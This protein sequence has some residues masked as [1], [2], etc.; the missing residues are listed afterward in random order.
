MLLDEG[1][2]VEFDRPATLLSDPSSRFYALCKA[3][4]KT[5]FSVLKRMAGVSES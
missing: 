4:G 5:E 1:R 2:I 3:T